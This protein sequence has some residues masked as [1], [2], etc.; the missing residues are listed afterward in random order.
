MFFK[1]KKKYMTILLT[2]FFLCL[3]YAILAWFFR[4]RT[5]TRDFDKFFMAITFLQLVVV[6]S[7][8]D[9]FSVPD[10]PSY[11]YMFFDVKEQNLSDFIIACFSMGDMVF[12]D[13]EPGYLL[14]TKIISLFSDNF[15]VFL[16]FVSVFRVFARLRHFATERITSNRQR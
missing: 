8:I 6:H 14:L 4:V 1:K 2:N 3:L 10:L 11:Y 16:F 13:I 7:F 15:T 9:P 12:I 5:K